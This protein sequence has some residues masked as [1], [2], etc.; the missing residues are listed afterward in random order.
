LQTQ[1][2]FEAANPFFHLDGLSLHE[3]VDLGL[4]RRILSPFFKNKNKPGF[5]IRAYPNPFHS[6]SISIEE[7]AVAQAYIGGVYDP[8]NN[9][10][11][12]VPFAQGPKMT[13]HRYDCVS[14]S[15]EAY[16]NPFHS[17]STNEDEKAVA[18][19]Y[20]SGVYD[21]YNNQVVFVPRVQANR[22]TWHRYNCSTQSIEAY[23]NPFHSTSTNEDQKVLPHAYYGGV[24]D[25]QNNQIVFVPFGQAPRMSW[26]RYDCVSQSI[27][28]YSNPFHSTST[29]EEEKAV[30]WA[31]VGGVYDPVNTSIVFAPY[32]QSDRR[33]WHRY[34]CTTQSIEAYSNP[35]DSTSE[36]AEKQAIAGSYI[37]GVYDPNNN[38]IVFVPYQG[39][40]T[41]WHRYDCVSQSILAYPNPFDATS[42]FSEEQAIAG[43]YQGG[44]YDPLN[45]QIVFVPS[46]QSN[47][48]TWHRFDCASQSIKAYP[49]SFDS[50]SDPSEEQAVWLAYIG[51]VYDPHNNQILTT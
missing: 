33:V 8:V 27:E 42:I 21:P 5:A 15:I 11:V 3:P 7:Q 4:L 32:V 13:W 19:A 43:A 35:F 46:H 22:A 14:Q 17:T 23:S 1:A 16:S 20:V 47:R 9:Q 44:V 39:A 12:F 34:N 41:T 28:A 25:P 24:Y 18:N 37:G 40:Q 51:G 6:T 30:L 38:Q 49:N 26:H 29:N 48:S 36:P 2:P 50:T 10:I 45:N 31:Y